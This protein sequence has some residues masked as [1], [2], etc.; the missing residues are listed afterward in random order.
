MNDKSITRKREDLRV[1]E[2]REDS[3]RTILWGASLL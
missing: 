1:S 2:G 3:L